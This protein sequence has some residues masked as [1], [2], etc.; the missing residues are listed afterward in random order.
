MTSSAGLSYTDEAKLRR[1]QLVEERNKHSYRRYFTSVGYSLLAVFCAVPFYRTKV[2]MQCR[3]EFLKLGREPYFT[4]PRDA[5]VHMWKNEGKTKIFRGVIPLFCF[6]IPYAFMRQSA[7]N[8]FSQ[9]LTD[10]SSPIAAYSRGF[11]AT[12][13]ASAAALI[14]NPFSLASNKMM[15]DTKPAKRAIY[16]YHG[17]TA[18]LKSVHSMGGFGKLFVGA[19]P[20]WLH[21]TVHYT[22]LFALTSL[23]SAT[24]TMPP[25]VVTLLSSIGAVL[26]AHP[27]DTIRSRMQY[28]LHTQITDF[29]PEYKG[30]VDC[31]KQVWKAEGI[32]GFYRGG[33][34]QMVIFGLATL[35]LIIAT[36]RS[37]QQYGKDAK[38]EA[39]IQ[40]RLNY[41]EEH[42]KKYQQQRTMEEKFY[43]FEIDDK[44]GV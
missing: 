12:T 24:Q 17:P 42:N 7:T 31:G 8:S 18:V 20:F 13:V 27:I 10:R 11:A 40:R 36:G 5:L 23:L 43:G 16:E 39:L 3:P 28:R 14:L 38:S 33:S 41:T 44:A 2:L 35:W 22:A 32:R 6:M 4:K 19:L 25:T 21:N 26:C 1:Q 30:M 9:D 15:A 34:S 29:V 37:H